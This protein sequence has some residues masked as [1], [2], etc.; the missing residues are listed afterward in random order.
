MYIFN[1]ILT[2]I[3]LLISSGL[4]SYIPQ[5]VSPIP[6]IK[7][8]PVQALPEPKLSEAQELSPV[9]SEAPI[10]APK[11]AVVHSDDYYLDWIAQHESSNNPYAINEI[12]ACGL[13]QSLPC[14]KVLSKCGSL[15][16]VACQQEWG[17]E[18]ALS[19]YG[20]TEAAFNFWQANRY[21]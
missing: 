16:N 13:Y 8:T 10:E 19:R 1:L 12:G 3:S 20:S 15:D 2:T 14:S 11:A 18:Y 7:Q 9:E 5:D 6:I 4:P 17:L 21:W